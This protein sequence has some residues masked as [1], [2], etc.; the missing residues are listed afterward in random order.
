M[1]AEKRVLVPMVNVSHNDNDSGFKIEVDLAG[2]SKKSV[3]LDMGSSGFCVRGE[4]EDFRYESCFMLAHEVRSEE[5]TAKFES[6]L[7]K[8][9]VPF[10]D[11]TRGTKVQVQ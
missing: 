10:K 2:A 3:D 4:G 9:S 5:A 11:G 8:I 1:T 7:L 6:G